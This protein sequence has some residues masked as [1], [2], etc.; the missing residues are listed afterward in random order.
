MTERQPVAEASVDGAPV[1]AATV[2]DA[3]LADA[4]A[5]LQRALADF[6]N[7]RKR[8]E[9]EVARERAAERAGVVRDWLPIVDNLERV[10]EHAQE[11]PSILIEGVRAVRD[12]AVDLLDRLGF[13]RFDDVGKQF[14]PSRH[15]AI[16][17]VAGD[18]PSGTVVDVVRPG[19]GT[20]E[21]VLRPAS[22]VVAGTPS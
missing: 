10:L 20:D 14:D 12:A 19:Y 2:V 6:D 15:D 7:L 5:R 8:Y 1:D 13:P 18:A 22:V 11:D 17:M 21:S 3:Q 4:E 9:R 16:A